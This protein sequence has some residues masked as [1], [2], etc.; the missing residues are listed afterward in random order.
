METYTKDLRWVKVIKVLDNKAFIERK[1]DNGVVANLPFIRG[2]NNKIFYINK[3]ISLKRLFIPEPLIKDIF[4]IV[5]SEGYLGF[6]RYYKV[7][8]KS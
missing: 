4:D 6:K 7:V 5:Y 8:L 2:N 3:F 1:F